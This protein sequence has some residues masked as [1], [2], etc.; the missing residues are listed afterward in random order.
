MPDYVSGRRI[1]TVVGVLCVLLAACSGDD[2]DEPDDGGEPTESTTTSQPSAS[3]EAELRP[4]IGDLLATW[5]TGM[6]DIVEVPRLVAD[7]PE[8]EMAVELAESFT[9]DSPYMQDLSVLMGSYVEQDTGI[10]PG[11]S[12]LAQRST[13]LRFT[14]APDDDHSSFVFCSY[15]EGVQ[16]PAVRRARPFAERRDRDRRG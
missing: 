6:T 5:D 7:D 1:G 13:L 16:L 8:H 4:Y 11:P 12:E 2:R 3:T 15:Q 10:H 9:D 14:Q